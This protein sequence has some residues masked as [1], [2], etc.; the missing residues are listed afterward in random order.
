[1]DRKKAI[2]LLAIIETLVFLIII[3][4]FLLGWVDLTGFIIAM[5]V[6]I[7]LSMGILFLII[8]KFQ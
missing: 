3:G 5:A 2:Y 1:M 6:A 7:L 4:I 8:R